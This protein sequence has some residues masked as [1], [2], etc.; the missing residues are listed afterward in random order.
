VTHIRTA[1]FALLAVLAACTPAVAQ[2]STAIGSPSEAVEPIGWIARAI[3]VPRVTQH[4]F[5]SAAAKAA[6]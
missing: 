6:P 3:K 5:E 2:A 4:M 1:I